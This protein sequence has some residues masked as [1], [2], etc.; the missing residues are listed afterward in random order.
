MRK[1]GIVKPAASPWASNVV[2]VKKEDGVLPF[3]V[4]YRRLNWV[5]KQN[6]YPLALINNCLNTVSG[7][8]WYSTFD[9]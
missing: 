5:T 6:S 1:H 4:D 7:S 2:L 9:L 8:S 3:C